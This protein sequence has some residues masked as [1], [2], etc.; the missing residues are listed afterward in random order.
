MFRH[1]GKKKDTCLSTGI[2]TG[3]NLSTRLQ[4]WDFPRI[5][6]IWEIS[7]MNDISFAYLSVVYVNPTNGKCNPEKPE[8]E[9]GG[10]TSCMKTTHMKTRK[11]THTELKTF[12]LAST[13]KERQLTDWLPSVHNNWQLAVVLHCRACHCPWMN[14]ISD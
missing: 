9:L 7:L 4:K 3:I 14:F 2:P 12:D 6:C 8:W 13:V 5:S 1:L 11:R 10:N